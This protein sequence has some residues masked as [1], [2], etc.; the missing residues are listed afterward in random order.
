M[1]VSKSTKFAQKSTGRAWAGVDSIDIALRYKDGTYM[2][3]EEF[4]Q[5]L[6]KSKKPFMAVFYK[7]VRKKSGILMGSDGN[8]IGGKWSFDADNR[9]KLPKNTSI[10]KFPKINE[11]NHTK[12]M[13]LE[14]TKNLV[15]SH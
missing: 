10:P 11:T 6:S 7:D 8:P 3:P 13:Y 15:Q 4:K 5:Y 9:N 1:V 14:D 12:T 2:P